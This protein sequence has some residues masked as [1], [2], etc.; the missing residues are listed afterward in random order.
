MVAVNTFQ[1]ILL[2]GTG[3]AAPRHLQHPQCAHK[4]GG[5][6]PVAT[7]GKDCK[8]DP[9]LVG[10]PLSDEWGTRSSS[11]VHVGGRKGG[12]Y[13]A[14]IYSLLP[15]GRTRGDGEQHGAPAW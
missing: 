4:I 6:D 7:Q 11:T 10:S 3:V 12:G 15:R 13:G 5:S 2:V 9:S 8:W 14:V 1:S